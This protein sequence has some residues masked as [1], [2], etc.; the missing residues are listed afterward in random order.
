MTLSLPARDSSSLRL[1]SLAVFFIILLGAGVER[2]PAE[3]A[4]PGRALE[5]FIFAGQSN[6]AGADA[7]LPDDFVFT[8]VD[9]DTLYTGA[10]L[11]VGASSEDYTPWGP[12]KGHRITSV[13]TANKLVGG[14]EFGF[15]RRL[16][17]SGA[18]NIAIIAAWGNFAPGTQ[19]WPW[20]EGGSLHTAWLAF[21]DDRLAEL[22]GK[23]YEIHL[24]GF[25]WHQGIDDGLNVAT[26]PHYQENL[27][28]LIGLVRKRFHMEN[29]PF[30]LARSVNSPIAIG[31]TGAGEGGAMAKVRAAQ[32]AVGEAVP[33]AG[34][35]NVDD[36][37]NV[38]RHHF[39]AESQ[40][41]IG[42][43]F[44]EVYLRLAAPQ[45]AARAGLENPRLSPR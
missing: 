43:R 34:W 12:L 7:V 23:G 25:V 39:S 33:H 26:A 37:P 45:E 24:R 19:A 3:G 32:V 44:G 29:A 4:G 38:L 41:I 20:S 35:V 22:R 18:R 8:A 1:W 17:E 30:V 28:A 5:V 36:L 14:P 40:L 11:P 42:R 31:A 16:A 9:Q 21:V 15:A 27:T 13:R 10:P 6:M 2:A